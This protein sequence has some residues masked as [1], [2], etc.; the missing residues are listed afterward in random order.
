[1]LHS[2]VN[3]LLIRLLTVSGL[4]TVKAIV[5]LW[6]LEGLADGNFF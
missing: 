3:G 5:L 6:L 4:A 2:A 1:M